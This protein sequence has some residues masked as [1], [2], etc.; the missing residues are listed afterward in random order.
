MLI[1]VESS[2]LR[3]TRWYEYASR[4]LFG[5]LVTVLTG[6]ITKEFGAVVA[7]LFLAFPAIFPASATLI[8]KHEREKRERAGISGKQRGRRMAGTNAAGAALGCMGLVA[9]A[10]VTWQMLPRISTTLALS[11]ATVAWCGISVLA[12]F[13]RRQHWPAS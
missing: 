9:F 2:V 7:G 1:R 4:F 11:L 5:G 12:W 10:L 13:I 8:E 3:Q 6:L